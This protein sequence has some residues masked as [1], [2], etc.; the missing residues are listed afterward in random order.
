MRLY[1]N[2]IQAAHELAEHLSFLKAECP[3]VLGLANVI[4]RQLGA[5]LDVLMIEKLF[6][7]DAPE[8]VVGAV[9]EHGRISFIQA[10]ARWH[11]VTSQQL[12]EPARE[13]LRF[14]QSRQAKIRELLPQ[15]EVK[16]RTVIV[17][18]QGL[19]TGAKMLGAVQSLKDR[20]ANKVIVAAPAGTSKAIW[21]LHE[22]ANMVVIPHQPTNFRGIDHF[23]EEYTDCTDDMVLNVVQQWVKDH[24]AAMGEGTGSIRTI[25]A[26]FA[27]QG[28]H[29]L[30]CDIDLPAKMQRGSGPYPAVVF[31]HGFESNAQSPRSVAISRRLAQREII[32]ARLDFTGHGKSEGSMEAATDQQMLVDLHTVFQQISGLNEVDPE[33]MGVVGSGTGGMIAL[34]YAAQMPRVKALVIRGPVCG[35]ETIA[36]HH[37]T[38]PTLIIHAEGDTALLDSVETLDRELAAPH[39]TLRISNSNRLFG[40]PISMEMM[41][42]ASVDWLSDHLI[43]GRKA[44]LSSSASVNASSATSELQMQGAQ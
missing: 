19:A 17:V 39:R 23:Y 16:N 8:I 3:L 26:R 13:A 15:T 11:H 37:V 43:V 28:G 31:A 14:M 22:A 35:R 30:S 41:I 5:T 36:A 40:D 38:A 44:P 9:D 33:S 20:G 32:G 29:S 24:P 1:K 6:A 42:A 27:T 12:V 10:A 25:T 18:G 4:A 2:R 7:P 21:Q 34:H